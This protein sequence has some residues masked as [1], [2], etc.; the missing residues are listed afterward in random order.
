M[1]RPNSEKLNL[2]FNIAEIFNSVK[3]QLDTIAPI[4]VYPGYG[5]W[6]VLSHDGAVTSGW[7]ESA[8]VLDANNEMDI[9]QTIKKFESL[10]LPSSF[11]HTK[12]TPL[13]T[14]SIKKVVEALTEQGYQI[15]RLRLS[16]LK[17]HSSIYW[18]TDSSPSHY[19]VRLHIPLVTNEKCFFEYENEKLHLKADGSAYM[20]RVNKKHR[21]SNSGDSIRYHLIMD[22]RD[23]KH[24]TQNFK[25]PEDI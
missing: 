1:Q 12:P 22:V 8:V 7:N 6:S 14:Q 18:H 16:F 17:P 20:I 15:A 13:F 3:T 11:E 19:A 5:G 24:Q 9:P 23:I 4:E 2:E 25:Y 10:N 21:Y